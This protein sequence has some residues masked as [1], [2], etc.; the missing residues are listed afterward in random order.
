[1]R[2]KSESAILNFAVNFIWAGGRKP[3]DND[4]EI[5]L[6]G[7]KWAGAPSGEAEDGGA[8]ESGVGEKKRAGFTKICAGNRN[9]DW[10]ERKAGELVEPRELKV[11][12]EEG[13]NG[14]GK[15]MAKGSAGMGF[16][17]TAPAGPKKA[18][19]LHGRARG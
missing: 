11:K 15:G 5:V 9:F 14:W 18:V 3:A 2:A 17:T 7:V 1:M 10:V 6:E 19:A 16:G 4:G 13:G 8:A 12:G